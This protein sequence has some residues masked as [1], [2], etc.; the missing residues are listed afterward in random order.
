M[1]RLNFDADLTFSVSHP[2]VSGSGTESATGTITASGSHI[3]IHSDDIVAMASSGS[4][5][6]LHAV[7]AGLAHRG[8]TLSVSGPHGTV[9][10][11][12]A[13]RSRLLHRL[14][15]R[16]PYVVVV[17]WR[18]AWAIRRG[19]RRRAGSLDGAAPGLMD[20]LP[21]PTVLP[22]APTFGR[23]RRPVTTTHDP[24]GGG[25]P[26]L[27]LSMGPAPTRGDTRKVF[28]LSPGVTTIGSS[29]DADL[30]LDGLAPQHAEIRRDDEDEYRLFALAPDVVT[31]VN[32][33][34][35]DQH[36]LRSGARIQLGA[37]K[38]SYSREEFADHGRPY[39]GREGGELSHQRDQPRPAYGPPQSSTRR[40]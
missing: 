8:L 27:V 37:W 25:R 9:V 4:D 32:G 1:S 14:L 39:G 2:A 16:S 5:R 17:G 35:A 31:L 10:V 23:I 34:V 15:T 24:L 7:A 21:P 19:Q 22:L 29:A 36:L 3:A 11:L 26:Q 33:A 28:R 18:E 38:L 20:L 13:V 30:G 6:T 12:G 40:P